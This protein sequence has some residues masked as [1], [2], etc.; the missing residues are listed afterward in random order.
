[1]GHNNMFFDE[2]YDR[3]VVGSRREDWFKDEPVNA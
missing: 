2:F 3:C 1:M